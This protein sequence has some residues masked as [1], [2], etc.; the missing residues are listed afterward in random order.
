[1]IEICNEE[2]L[3]K[4]LINFLKLICFDGGYLPPNFITEYEL[5]RLEFDSNGKLIKMTKEKRKMVITFY[6]VFYIL[7]GRVLTK[8]W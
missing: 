8:P 1:M 2:V 4:N 3:G 7:L 6:L 5:D